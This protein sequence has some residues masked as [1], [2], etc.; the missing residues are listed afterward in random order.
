[1]VVN[2][3]LD[4]LKEDRHLLSSSTLMVDADTTEQGQYAN[5]DYNKIYRRMFRVAQLF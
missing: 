4:W 3:L 5:L 1:M 2:R